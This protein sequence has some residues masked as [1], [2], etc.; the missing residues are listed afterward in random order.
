MAACA[1]VTCSGVR[2]AGHGF[3]DVGAA[4]ETELLDIKEVLDATCVLDDDGGLVAAAELVEVL[5]AED[6]PE[7][8][9]SDEVQPA[10]SKAAD[11]TRA[12]IAD[13]RTIDRVITLPSKCGNARRW[14]RTV[15]DRTRGADHSDSPRL[16]SLRD[17]YCAAQVH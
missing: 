15:V 6:E 3:A 10:K 14:R 1:C 9:A 17:C 5:L 12:A 7:G 4:A 11:T 8:P 13:P 16:P 2:S